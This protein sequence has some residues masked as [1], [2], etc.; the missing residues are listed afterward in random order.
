MPLRTKCA[1][2]H[3]PVYFSFYKIKNNFA[4]NTLKTASKSAISI[5]ITQKADY[6]EATKAQPKFRENGFRDWELLFGRGNDILMSSNDHRSAPPAHVSG[7]E[8]ACCA[9]NMGGKA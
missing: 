2:R 7:I 1:G 8:N 5:D 3:F 4:A 9:K 6:T